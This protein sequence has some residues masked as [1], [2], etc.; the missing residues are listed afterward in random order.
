MVELP[1]YID[2]T[3]LICS[4]RSLMINLKQY[5]ADERDSALVAMLVLP[6]QL[7]ITK[8]GCF[9]TY[10]RQIFSHDRSPSE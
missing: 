1:C 8:L 6:Q 2:R 9:V 10:R 5:V 4:D 7:S 3:A